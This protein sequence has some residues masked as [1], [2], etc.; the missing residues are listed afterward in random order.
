RREPV[1]DPPVHHLPKPRPGG[2]AVEHLEGLHDAGEQDPPVRAG[3]GD[4]VV[5]DER[6]VRV[7]AVRDAV[8]EVVRVDGGEDGGLVGDGLGDPGVV[9]GERAL[10]DAVGGDVGE[11]GAGVE[12][13]VEVDV[14][15][16][17]VAEVGVHRGDVRGGQVG[18]FGA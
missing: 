5:L 6:A 17:A 9:G 7:V 3:V 1:G 12:A 14:A 8:F 18:A 4:G 10:E 2:G 16:S 11:V 15:V 13:G